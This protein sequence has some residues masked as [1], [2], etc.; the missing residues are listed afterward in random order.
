MHVFWIPDTITTYLRTA[1]YLVLESNTGL[2]I[3][4]FLD[5]VPVLGE[6]IGV[7]GVVYV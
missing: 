6:L 7:D 1:L 3:F 2:F 4:L 5:L